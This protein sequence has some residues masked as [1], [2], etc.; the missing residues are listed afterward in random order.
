MLR[1]GRCVARQSTYE[2]RDKLVDPAGFV[3]GVAMTFG[4]FI[5]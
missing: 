5:T 2:S 3:F 1:P 4:P